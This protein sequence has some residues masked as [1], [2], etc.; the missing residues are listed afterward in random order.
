MLYF[1][2][3]LSTLCHLDV[4]FLVNSSDCEEKI[5]KNIE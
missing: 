2:V 4:L 5:V 3:Q 1:A